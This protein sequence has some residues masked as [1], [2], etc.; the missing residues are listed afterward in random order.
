MAITEKTKRLLLAR[1]GGFCANPNCN[2]DL[3]PLLENKTITNIEELAHIIGKSEDGPRG[4][5][6][7]QLSERDDYKNIIV[8]CPT[9]HTIIDKNPE[10]FPEEKL[11]RWK[12]NHS[13]RIFSLFGELEYSSRDDMRKEISKIQAANKMIFNI[14]G[15]HSKLAK[16]KPW[17]AEEIWLKKSMAEIIPN[18]RKIEAILDRYY[19]L[20]TEPEAILFEEWRL[21]KD[22]F[23]YNKL[24][25]DITSA[26]I[27]YPQEFN[28]ILTDGSIK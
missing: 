7:L 3:F 14:Y 9:C 23:E 15:P 13:E 12:Q 22:S 5:G 17:E 10:N 6:S 28:R 25:G 11:Q 8:L 27:V 21:H 2:K 24:S 16:E 26:T 19:N 18:N 4:E 1:S 20:L